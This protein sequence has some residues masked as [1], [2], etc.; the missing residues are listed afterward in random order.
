VACTESA[1]SEV[2]SE[3]APQARGIK[4]VKVWKE[5]FGEFMIDDKEGE[6]KED[7]SV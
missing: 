1:Q 2:G 3:R 5:N 6:E 4:P 7:G